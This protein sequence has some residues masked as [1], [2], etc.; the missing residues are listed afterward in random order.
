MI[1]AE[2]LYYELGAMVTAPDPFGSVHSPPLEDVEMSR[3]DAGYGYDGYNGMDR[4]PRDGLINRLTDLASVPGIPVSVDSTFLRLERNTGNNAELAHPR[5]DGNNIGARFGSYLN[6]IEW[7]PEPGI[8][9]SHG[10]D[11]PVRDDV[12]AT[13]AKAIAG[14]DGFYFG[15]IDTQGLLDEAIARTRRAIYGR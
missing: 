12:L 7:A 6:L 2:G 1:G 10:F 15:T 4:Q 14:A 11:A 3:Q 5:F 13:E 8:V 9:R